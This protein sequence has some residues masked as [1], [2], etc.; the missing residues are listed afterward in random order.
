MLLHGGKLEDFILFFYCLG[1]FT[2]ESKVKGPKLPLKIS[3]FWLLRKLIL[4]FSAVCCSKTLCCFHP[5]WKSM[6]K[7]GGEEKSLNKCPFTFFYLFTLLYLK[8]LLN[9]VCKSVVEK[10]K[11]CGKLWVIEYKICGW[12]YTFFFVMFNM[13]ISCVFSVC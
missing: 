4:L 1:Y 13:I 12:L 11:E 7:G 8:G 6:C 2:I 10:N 3:F 5:L 9:D